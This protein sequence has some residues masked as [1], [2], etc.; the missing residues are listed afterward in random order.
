MKY[1][2]NKGEQKQ[3]KLHRQAIIFSMTPLMRC[4]P[5]PCFCLDLGT[6]AGG[7]DPHGMLGIVE[8]CHLIAIG[9]QR[10]CSSVSSL[11]QEE[12]NR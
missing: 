3:G 12:W 6:L 1:H 8:F 7:T 10:D 2:Q 5:Q 4:E 11:K 9:E